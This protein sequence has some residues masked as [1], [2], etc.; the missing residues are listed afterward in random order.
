MIE[1]LKNKF[2]SGIRPNIY[3]WRDK[4]GHEI[5]L[6]LEQGNNLIPIEIKSGKT[7]NSDYFENIKYWNKLSQQES[8]S[9]LIYCGEN[10]KR[11]KSLILNW[12]HLE[13]LFSI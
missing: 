13:A 12:Q 4:V 8:N 11:Q 9:F 2:H 7:L 3:F 1:Y 10:Q 6:L 5:D